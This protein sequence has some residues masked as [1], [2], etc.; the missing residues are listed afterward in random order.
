MK[1]HGQEWEMA[2]LRTDCLEWGEWS[3]WGW[4]EVFC[5]NG[6]PFCAKN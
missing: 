4:I 6:K 3:V 1:E 5:A 2:M